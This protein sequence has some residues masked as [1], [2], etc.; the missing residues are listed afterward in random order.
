MRTHSAPPLRG[1]LLPLLAVVALSLGATSAWAEA[2]HRCEAV[3]VGPTKECELLGT[4]TVS[5]VGRSEG[6][7]RKVALGRLAELMIAALDERAAKTAGTASAALAESQR[8]SCPAAAP[9]AATVVCYPEPTL[10]EDQL[11][12]GQLRVPECY[13]GPSI[14]LQGVGYKMLEKARDQIC[15]E[16][17]LELE[18]AGATAL[19]RLSCQVE[20]MQRAEVRCAASGA[21]R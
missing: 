19:S 1:P 2:P 21:G 18:R 17:D 3:F 8:K 6:G 12:F 14:D 16:V 13:R 9:A 15:T 7:A 11:C 4:W 20:C 10:A 5:G